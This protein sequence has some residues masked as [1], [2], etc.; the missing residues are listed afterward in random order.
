MSISPYFLTL[1]ENQTFTYQKD[2]T[3]KIIFNKKPQNEYHLEIHVFH[4]TQVGFIKRIIQIFEHLLQP[5][6]LQDLGFPCHH[7]NH[8]VIATIIPHFLCSTLRLHNSV[9]YATKILDDKYGLYDFYSH[10]NVISYKTVT[11]PGIG[12]ITHKP[13]K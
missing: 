10:T 11:L 4:P 7:I 2:F 5:T 13:T 12:Q 9:L 3:Y 1:V 6:S 8:T